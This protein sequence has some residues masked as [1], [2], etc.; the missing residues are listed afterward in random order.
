[1]I[2]FDFSFLSAVHRGRWFSP[3]DI[4]TF[5]FFMIAEGDEGYFLLG[6]KLMMM[7]RREE[8]KWGRSRCCGSISHPVPR[9]VKMAHYW[10]NKKYAQESC[11]K[12]SAIFPKM[13][14]SRREVKKKLWCSWSVSAA[15]YGRGGGLT[16]GGWVGVSVSSLL[17]LPP[18]PPFLW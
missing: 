16:D 13:S 12:I 10:K 14:L 18:L 5:I 15:A 11:A 17:P 9:R 8:G 1:M 3:C 6:C 4:K 7:L 2:L